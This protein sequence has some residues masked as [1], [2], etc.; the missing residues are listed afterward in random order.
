M[1]AGYLDSFLFNSFVMLC[2]I[3][4]FGDIIRSV[5]H[6]RIWEENRFGKMEFALD[7][8]YETGT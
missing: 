4:A 6:Y 1:V 2:Y 8:A 5:G 7:L 3:R